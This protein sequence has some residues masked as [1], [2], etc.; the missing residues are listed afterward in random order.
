MVVTLC[1]WCAHPGLTPSARRLLH[2]KGTG[3]A[4]SAF[5]P[6]KLQQSLA[7]EG[8]DTGTDPSERRELQWSEAID[9]MCPVAHLAMV[10]VAH[11]M[12]AYMAVSTSQVRA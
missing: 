4:A 10:E 2:L 12:Q 9:A 1:R 3:R 7:P 11:G 6:S 5:L 8:S